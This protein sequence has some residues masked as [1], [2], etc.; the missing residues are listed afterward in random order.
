MTSFSPVS[1]FRD[2]FVSSGGSAPLAPTHR[3]SPKEAQQ[4]SQGQ[5]RIQTGVIVLTQQCAD[6]CVSWARQERVPE[7]QAGKVQHIPELRAFTLM[8]YYELVIVDCCQYDF[9]AAWSVPTAEAR[10]PSRLDRCRELA[11]QALPSSLA[12]VRVQDFGNGTP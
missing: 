5:M 1:P 8:A 9:P 11:V 3:S 12:M 4:S 2:L 6:S 7:W 10:L